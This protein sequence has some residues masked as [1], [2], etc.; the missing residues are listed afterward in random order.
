MIYNRINGKQ[1]NSYETILGMIK[2]KG[3]GSLFRGF[4]PTMIKESTTYG[5]RFFIY[6]ELMDI[7]GKDKNFFSCIA[8]SSIAGVVSSILNN[9]LD[10]VQ[11]RYQIP[12]STEKNI[13]SSIRN[14]IK[15][16]GFRVLY[17]GTLIRSVRTIPAVSISFLT[18]EKICDILNQKR[19]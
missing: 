8:C 15:N 11:T 1:L 2:E 3:Y 7:Y 18:Y 6:S 13:F 10:V 5:F 14:I 9:P 4:Y 19:N 17:K 12:N 16:E